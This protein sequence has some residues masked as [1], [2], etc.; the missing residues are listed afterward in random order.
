VSDTVGF[1]LRDGQVDVVAV[2]IGLRARK[3]MA[4][5]SVPADD[6]AA[7]AIRGR[8]AEA[9][10]RARRAHVG[11]P[12]RAVVAKAV[13]LPPVPGSDLRRMVG[14]E[15]ERHLPFPPAD[16]VFDFE[17]LDSGPGR[18]VR[19]LLVAVER[20]SYDRV[21]QLLRDVGLTPRLISVGVHSLA[22]TVESDPRGR[23]VVWVEASDAELAVIVGDR[24]VGSRAFPLPPEGEPRE[25]ALA[26]ELV[27]TLAA[28][29]EVDRAKVAE[30]VVGGAVPLELAS[31]LSVDELPVR[32]GTVAPPG[33]VASDDASL[34]ALAV[35]LERPGRKPFVANLL[36]DDLRPRPFPWP[37]AATA[38]LALL[39]LGIGIAIPTVTFV[40]ERRALAALD[41]EISRLAPD[42][43]RAEQLAAEVERARREL[44]TLRAFED[45]GLRP[46]P[47][48]QELTDT[49]PADAWLTNLSLDRGGLELAGFANAAS[50]LIPLLEASPGLERVEFTSPVTKGRDREQFRLRALWERRSGGS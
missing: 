1:A 8:L 40:R 30:I 33:L 13:E 6:G 15:L 29:P 12:R 37:L 32:M 42:V 26:A 46:L 48:L 47:V 19:V 45:Q 31:A 25:Q 5:F 16:A 35:A 2:R 24:V 18:P 23:I 4:A 44:A 49:L 34:P 39:T 9:G 22:R 7:A 14:F 50:Q 20:R 36:P 11:L 28:L 27:R 3:V 38:A 21:R 17:V 41:V 10:V 43:R